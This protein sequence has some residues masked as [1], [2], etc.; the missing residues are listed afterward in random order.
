M[1]NPGLRAFEQCNFS[2]KTHFWKNCAVR[3]HRAALRGALENWIFPA[4][5]VFPGAPRSESQFSPCPQSMRKGPRDSTGPIACTGMD[6][7]P[8]QVRLRPHC[9][10]RRECAGT[11]PRPGRCAPT[12]LRSH[13]R[14]HLPLK[15]VAGT[16]K[17]VRAHADVPG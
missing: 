17:A 5:G 15:L 16:D 11:T 10:A 6:T 14:A 12:L 9:T 13:A 2:K 3:A 1:M 4:A 7:C 8:A